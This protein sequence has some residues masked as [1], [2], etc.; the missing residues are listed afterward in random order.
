MKKKQ[1]NKEPLPNLKGTINVTVHD[2]DKEH[3]HCLMNFQLNVKVASCKV[4]YF[5]N[6]N[7]AHNLARDAK[8]YLG[9]SMNVLSTL[10]QEGK[11]GIYLVKTAEMNTF[12]E[13]KIVPGKPCG[14][15]YLKKVENEV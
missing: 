4:T 6:S 13:F 2:C 14:S 9:I 12:R 7:L 5:R 3:Q 11:V 10:V 15:W 8:N 1:Q